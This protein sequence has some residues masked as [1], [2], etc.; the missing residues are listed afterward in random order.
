[1]KPFAIVAPRRENV[2]T[3]MWVGIHQGEPRLVNDVSAALQF[4]RENDAQIFARS[5]LDPGYEWGVTSDFVNP[6]VPGEAP[7]KPASEDPRGRDPETGLQY[8]S[9]CGMAAA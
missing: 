7:L 3:P 1:M 4:A 5:F 9:A 6:P 8:P 2:H